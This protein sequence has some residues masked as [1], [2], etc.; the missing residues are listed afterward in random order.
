MA[1]YSH[2][3]IYIKTYEFVKLIYRITQQFRKEYKYSLGVELQQLIWKILDGIIKANSL[4]DCEKKEE[5]YKISEYFDNF[6]IRLRLA[7]EIGLITNTKFG[8]IQ[9][10]MEEIGKMIG[11]WQKW[12]K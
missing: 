9:K 3:P 7:Y 4:L 12:V 6:K 8:V 11:G 10:D 5:I 1:Q 2:L